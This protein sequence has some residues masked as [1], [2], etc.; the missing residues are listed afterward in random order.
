MRGLGCKSNIREPGCLS[1]AS[2]ATCPAHAIDAL[3]RL[4]HTSRKR[5]GVHEAHTKYEHSTSYHRMEPSTP[6]LKK[7][8]GPKGSLVPLFTTRLVEV[9]IFVYYYLGV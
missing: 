9:C 3:C 2:A 8:G 7:G 5:I 1:S 4:A 6:S